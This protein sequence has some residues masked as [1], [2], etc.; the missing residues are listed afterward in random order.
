MAEIWL[1]SPYTHTEVRAIRE[2]L[3][4]A[5]AREGR[6]SMARQGEVASEAVR[7]LREAR[8]QVLALEVG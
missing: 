3:E 2:A 5:R 7:P 6:L 8:Q 1:G 4:A